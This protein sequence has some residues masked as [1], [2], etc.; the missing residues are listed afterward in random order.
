MAPS[1]R[2]LRRGWFARVTAQRQV[3]SA[4]K[5]ADAAEPCRATKEFP[6]GAVTMARRPVDL[7]THGGVLPHGVRRLFGVGPRTCA[8]RR[9]PLG[10]RR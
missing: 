8:I 9:V 10:S 4:R 1:N 6:A 7:D 5:L 3:I 2:W